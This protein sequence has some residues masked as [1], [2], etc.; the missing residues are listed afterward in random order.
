MK[1][2]IL[3][4]EEDTPPVLLDK[5]NEIFEISGLSLL[6]NPK[7]FYEPIICWLEEYIQNPS[8]Q[9]VFTF[10]LKYFNTTSAKEI[11]RLYQILKKLYESKKSQ[12]KILWYYSK[13]D[14]GLRDFGNNLLN[15]TV[16]F[17]E[18][19]Y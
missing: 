2:L 10:K 8:E 1:P 13:E 15:E 3:I 14:E 7:K 9:T 4:P 16:L 17:E 19:P 11:V 18:I 12:V 5:E 6:E